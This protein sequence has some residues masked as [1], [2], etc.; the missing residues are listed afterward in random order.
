MKSLCERYDSSTLQQL[1][2]I[3]TGENNEL[4]TKDVFPVTLVQSVFDGLTGTRL[5]QILALNNCMWLPFNG[6]K[7]ATRLQVGPDMRRKGL[8]VS[9]RDLENTV[10]TQRYIKEDTISD[11]QW[12]K[13]SNW[14]DVF[15]G[16]D[17]LEVIQQLKEYLIEYINEETNSLKEMIEAIKT[18][19]MQIVEELPAV[20]QNG[21]IYLVLD[22][23]SEDGNNTYIEYVWINAEQR[24]EVIGSLGNI[25][26][27]DTLSDTSE[28]PVQNKVITE[29]LKKIN[30]SLPEEG[31]AGQVL[32][33]TEDGY[34]WQDP[35]AAFP[36]GGTE[37]QVLKK[38]SSGVEW[39]NDKDTT[40]QNASQS[41]DGLM[42][43]EDKTKLDGITSAYATILTQEEYDIL[44]PK[45]ENRI[46]YIKG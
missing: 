46:Y 3:I 14:E 31:T 10:H 15:V 8:I 4:T 40:Y 1:Y 23:E 5:D 32:T 26:V 41:Q 35:Q 33:K 43:A 37:G 11:E 12:G 30:T 17:N 7:E 38:T 25:K 24:Y 22:P 9:F 13:D 6:T 20:G 16:F 28:N 42:S 44:N 34:K 27:D 29:A 39:A 18:M 45:E 36:E 19:E 21:V 2:K